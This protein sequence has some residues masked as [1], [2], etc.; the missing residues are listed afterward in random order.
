MSQLAPLIDSCPQ[1]SGLTELSYWC[2]SCL[3][4]KVEFDMNTK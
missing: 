4:S 1:L 2:G 3:C